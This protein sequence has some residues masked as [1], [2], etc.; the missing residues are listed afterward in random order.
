MPLLVLN[1]QNLELS[2]RVNVLEPYK[3]SRHIK[4][5]CKQLVSIKQEFKQKAM[6]I[7]EKDNEQDIN[8]AFQEDQKKAEQFQDYLRSEF[9]EKVL[10]VM[11]DIEQ[12]NKSLNEQKE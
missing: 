7:T 11:A 2:V 1:H 4:K 3:P 12:I 10:K 8:L 6:D 5:V 9:N